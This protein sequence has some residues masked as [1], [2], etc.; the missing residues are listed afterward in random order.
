MSNA[1]GKI[2]SVS[3]GIVLVGIILS[4]MPIEIGLPSSIYDFLI[5]GFIKDVFQMACYFFPVQF[6]FNC[7]L[8]IFVANHF[9]IIINIVTWIYDIIAK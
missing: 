6:A 7:L 1:I 3:V 8:V 4:Y 5:N 2:I 9:G